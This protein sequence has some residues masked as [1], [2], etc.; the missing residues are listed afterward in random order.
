MLC[1]TYIH[2]IWIQF[3]VNKGL[4]SVSEGVTARRGGSEKKI[5][6]DQVEELAR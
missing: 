4:Q 2:E 1:G 3:H 6:H 5:P